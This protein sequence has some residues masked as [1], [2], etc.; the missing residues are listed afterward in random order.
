MMVDDLSLMSNFV[1]IPIRVRRMMDE[2]AST[3][4][5][6]PDKVYSGPLTSSTTVY[7]G[8]STYYGML[9]GNGNYLKERDDTT[10]TKDKPNPASLYSGLSFNS[11]ISS[12]QGFK[13][14]FNN[15]SIFR[16][17]T[18][19]SSDNGYLKKARGSARSTWGTPDTSNLNSFSRAANGTTS[20]GSSKQY[21]HRL[22]RKASNV[23]KYSQ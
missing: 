3:A 20:E 13:K 8:S 7:P 16:K 5:K 11:D 23:K 19:N 10:H 22:P 17:R 12:R 21:S 4:S 9:S 14:I 15:T 6:R 2:E 1:S 18:V